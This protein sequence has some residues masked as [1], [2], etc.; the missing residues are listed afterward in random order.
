MLLCNEALLRSA[1]TACITLMLVFSVL[2][3]ATPSHDLNALT[4]MT[5]EQHAMQ[6]QHDRTASHSHDERE[7][8]LQIS[9]HLHGHNSSD[10][11]HE[12]PAAPAFT[13]FLFANVE[14]K[15]AVQTPRSQRFDLTSRLERPPRTFLL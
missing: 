9:G 13:S 4:H 15:H 5:V 3:R 12:T 10:H 2:G 14:Q 11:S 1:L 8:T 7:D 6:E